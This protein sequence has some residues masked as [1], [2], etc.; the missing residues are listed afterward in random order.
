MPHVIGRIRKRT[1]RAVSAAR[2]NTSVSALNAGRLQAKLQVGPQN[3][4]YER[5]A[6][7]V[8]DRVMNA[9]ET[10]A[11]RACANCED[12]DKETAQR[13]SQPEEEEESLQMK[14][15]AD[16]VQR[17]AMPEEEEELQA[18][19]RPDA[20][21]RETVEEED[22]LQ[23]KAHADTLQRHPVGEEEE[24][25]QAKARPD[26]AQRDAME[27]EEEVQAKARSDGGFQAKA[28]T[29]AQVAG[30]KGGGAPL[31][32]SARAFFEPRFGAD[33]SDVRV[34]SGPQA[35]RAAQALGARAF[36]TGRDV[37]F[38]AGEY[39]PQSHAGG[40]LLAHELTHVLQQRGAKPRASEPEAALPVQRWSIGSD[41]V[42]SHPNWQEV[43]D[44]AGRSANH[45][46][47]LNRARS[48]VA[49]L[50]NSA[51][52]INYFRDNCD[53]GTASSLRQGFSSAQVYHVNARG[54]SFGANPIGSNA[55]AYNVTAYRQGS[56]FLAATLLHEIYHSCAPSDTNAEAEMKAETALQACRLYAPVIE[57]LSA[58]Q[59]AIGAQIRI[60]GYGFGPRRHAGGRVELAGVEC[61]IVSWRLTPG[62]SD[63]MLT[64]TIPQG[65]RTGMLRVFNNGVRSN[66]RRFT[67]V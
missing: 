41:P 13:Q 2:S 9:P 60:K 55:I 5:E 16:S 23:A 36:T 40:L 45:I 38:G 14:R 10:A 4:V 32:N 1:R 31:S 15:A 52:C 47:R 30:L 43:P 19:L 39:A 67:V 50:L 44:G 7:R 33:F 57:R 6:D 28:S 61:P 11:Q 54:N 21:Q 62:R 42:P 17:E 29:S 8:A 20:V 22:A 56:R 3:D 58:T 65:A 35:H 27:E 59:G 34:H 18:K 46:P 64:V 66:A 25:L 12:K 49:R 24:D 63:V 53:G 37:V 51:A 48:I 26:G